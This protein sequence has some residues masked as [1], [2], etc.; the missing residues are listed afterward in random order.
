M[1]IMVVTCV[2]IPMTLLPWPNSVIAKQPGSSSE[3][4]R[5]KSSVWC[6]AVPSFAMAPPQRVKCTPAFMQRL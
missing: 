6:F 1:L 4:R 5:G 3:S 2:S